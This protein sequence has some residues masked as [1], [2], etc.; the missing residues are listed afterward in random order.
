[1]NIEK[2]IKQIIIEIDNNRNLVSDEVI[3]NTPKRISEFYKEIFSGL[4][5]DPTEYL[6][7]KFPIDNDN[8]ILEK[9]IIFHS[10]CEHHFLP[11]FGKIDIGYIPNGNIVGFGDLIKVIVAYSKRPQLQERLGEEIAECIYRELDCKG[12][13]LRMEAEHLCMTM[14]GVKAPGSKII[15]TVAKGCFQSNQSLRMEFLALSK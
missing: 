9:N 13:Y 10:M 1:M 11:F 3:E 12:V 5:Q 7:K 2:N 4:G 15:T 8:M 14:R 6:K